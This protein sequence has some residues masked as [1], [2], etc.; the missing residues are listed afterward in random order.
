MKIKQIVWQLALRKKEQGSILVDKKTLFTA[1]PNP[2]GMWAADPFIIE[3]D[4]KVY[5]FAELFSL[6]KWRG[7]IGYC[8]YE[9]GKFSKWNIIFADEHHYSYPY[10]FEKENNI[11]MMPETGSVKEI[12]IYKAVDFP[13]KWEKQVVIFS[14]EKMVDSIFLADDVILTY[15]MFGIFKNNLVLLKKENYGWQE[16]SSIV[17]TQEIKR[18]AGKV[19]SYNNDF[20]RPAQD[21]RNLYG[22]AIKFFKCSDIINDIGSEQQIGDLRPEEIAVENLNKKIVGAHTYNATLNYEIIDVQC[23]RFSFIGLLNR[24]LMRFLKRR[25]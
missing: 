25:R 2:V 24:V 22:G 23:Y 19:F 12:A 16:I 8:I 1:V 9:N 7:E 10:V 15:K 17:D 18:P 6:S 4:N 14:G 21:G 11:F 5:I 20:V 3:R 13:S